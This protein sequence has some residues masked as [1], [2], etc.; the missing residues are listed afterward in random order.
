ML[1]GYFA[2]AKSAYNVT[3]TEYSIHLLNDIIKVQQNE[4]TQNCERQQFGSTEIFFFFLI[5][6][7]YLQ[8]SARSGRRRTSSR[9]HAVTVTKALT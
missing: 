8:I 2:I 7:G 4:H 3:N 9:Y 6:S 1:N 5:F